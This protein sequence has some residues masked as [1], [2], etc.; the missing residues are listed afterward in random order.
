M[1]VQYI[2]SR[3]EL[4][5]IIKLLKTLDEAIEE[6]TYN[7]LKEDIYNYLNNNI[8]DSEKTLFDDIISIPEYNITKIKLN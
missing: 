1:E 2:I 5:S 4:T 3:E 7:S 6:Y 8:D